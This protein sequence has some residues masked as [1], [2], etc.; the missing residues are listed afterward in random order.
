MY[1]DYFDRTH[2][3]MKIGDQKN[4]NCSV[5]KGQHNEKRYEIRL[6][7]SHLFTWWHG[8]LCI[9]VF[10]D[11]ILDFIRFLSF[12]QFFHFSNFFH[13]FQFFRLFSFFSKFFFFHF[14]PTHLFPKKKMFKHSRDKSDKFWQPGFFQTIPVNC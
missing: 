8:Y 2:F 7:F 13:F 3:C 1:A 6:N 11:F 14:L 10:L 4:L 9:L 5:V 12:F